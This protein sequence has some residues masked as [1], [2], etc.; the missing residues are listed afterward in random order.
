[1]QTPVARKLLGQM[2]EGEQLEEADVRALVQVQGETLF[3]DFKDGAKLKE[4]KDAARMV[5][6]YVSGFA[7]AD[8]GLLVV[9][10]SD[11]GGDP[12]KRT[13]TPTTAPGGKPLCEWARNV[14][15][16]M[17]GG[18]I[19]APRIQAIPVDGIEVLVIGT[20]RAPALVPCLEEGDLK[21]Y[22]RVGDSTPSIPAYLISDLVLGRRVHPQLLVTTC[23]GSS[24]AANGSAANFGFD[25][26][27]EGMV[28]ADDVIV[29]VVSFGLRPRNASNGRLASSPIC[30]F[31]DAAPAPDGVGEPLVLVHVTSRSN[32]RPLNLAAFERGSARGIGDLLV[33]RDAAPVPVRS[34]LYVVANGH[35]PDWYQFDWLIPASGEATLST[36]LLDRALGRPI[37]AWNR[38]WRQP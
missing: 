15:E 7:N 2:L 31:I 21:Y 19:P 24:G 30:N 38:E 35:P 9:G 20:A 8:G 18:L 4:R 22:L 32:Q 25:V 33:P 28:P 11:G 16:S 10:V 17:A 6:R 1:M 5:R 23:A 14:L 27:N 37:V 26:E 3:V 36:V 29:G 13:F 34:A 12:T